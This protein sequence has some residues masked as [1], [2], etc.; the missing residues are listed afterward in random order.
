MITRSLLIDAPQ[1]LDHT[2]ERASGTG[3]WAG[4]NG[5]TVG[6]GAKPGRDPVRALGIQAGYRREQPQRI[7]DR[8]DRIG[9][10]GRLPLRLNFLYSRKIGLAGRRLPVSQR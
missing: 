5:Q 2:Q 10:F 3:L 7:V 6:F 1:P 4:Q 9:R 8:G